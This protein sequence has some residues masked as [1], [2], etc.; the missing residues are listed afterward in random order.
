MDL[1]GGIL[2]QKELEGTFLRYLSG[3]TSALEDAGCPL[4]GHIKL[5][6]TSG[7]DGYIVANTTSFRE[8]PTAKGRLEGE[9]GRG[10]LT[11]HAV[12]YGAETR[13]LELIMKDILA[14]TVATAPGL[15]LPG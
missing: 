2:G 15:H 11:V 12:V 3:L 10:R 8:P 14:E 4:I 5:M 13:L 7:R 6:F 1:D 9:A